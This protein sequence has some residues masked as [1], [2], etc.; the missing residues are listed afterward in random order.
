[1]PGPMRSECRRTGRKLEAWLAI[2]PSCEARC[3]TSCGCRAVLGPRLDSWIGV[4]ESSLSQACAALESRAV[5]ARRRPQLVVPEEVGIAIIPVA[6][7]NHRLERRAMS[8]EAHRA[9][10]PDGR[11]LDLHAED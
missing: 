2:L 5:R 11:R 4:N 1:M 8:A 3:V 10:K 7:P 6:G 9:G